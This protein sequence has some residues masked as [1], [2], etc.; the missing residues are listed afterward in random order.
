M[1]HKPAD[2]KDYLVTQDWGNPYA[3]LEL[4]HPCP[5]CGGEIY[6][7]ENGI[8]HAWCPACHNRGTVPIENLSLQFSWRVY[9]F[10]RKLKLVK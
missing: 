3:I 2:L 7:T 1:K 6:L 10:L 5:A 4:H 8:V 9:R